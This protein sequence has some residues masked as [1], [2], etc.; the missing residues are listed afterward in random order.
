[1]HIRIFKY[2]KF[3]FCLFK[4]QLTE[5]TVVFP[6][7]AEHPAHLYWCNNYGRIYKTKVTKII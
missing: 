7:P 4:V 1:M 3:N 2:M 6:L 5:Y